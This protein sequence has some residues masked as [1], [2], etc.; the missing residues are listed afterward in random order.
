MYYE[1]V[2]SSKSNYL[3]IS[4]QVSENF[5]FPL[6][7]HDSYEFICVE[8]GSL[9]VE[10]NGFAFDVTKGYGALILPNQ[11]HEFS[12]PEYSKS[13]LVI[14][15]PDHIPEMKKLTSSKKPFCPVIKAENDRLRDD[16]LRAEKNPLRVRSILYELAARYF[17]GESAPQLAMDDGALVC[18]VV[19]YID[20]HYKDPMT[21]EDMSTALGYSYRY[22]SGVVNRFFKQPLPKVVNRYRVNFACDLLANTDTEITQ[23]ALAC[24]FGS[25]RSFNRNFKSVMEISPREYRNSKMR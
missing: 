2:R 15:S 9:R 11:P 21:L 19:E 12:T 4:P 20:A 8:D 22:M 5:V 13:W 6:H 10:I 1:Q 25:M 14:F 7:L 18:R 3:K 16:L 24:G 17:E 23:I